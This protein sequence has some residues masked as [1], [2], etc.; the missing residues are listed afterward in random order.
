MLAS[1]LESAI[2][3]VVLAIFVVGAVAVYA[4]SA[5][6]AHHLASGGHPLV[7]SKALSWV[8][9]GVVLGSVALLAIAAV[10]VAR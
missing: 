5:W 10:S 7:S 2:A 4:G 1:G 6:E 8:S 3:T 9:V